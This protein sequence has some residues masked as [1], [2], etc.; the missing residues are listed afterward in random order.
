MN[1]LF[2]FVLILFF[3][4][5][6]VSLVTTQCAVKEVI[7]GTSKLKSGWAAVDE[8][9]SLSLALWSIKVFVAWDDP[10]LIDYCVG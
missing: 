4:I 1:L 3:S 7:M 8:L 9:D 10:L 6:L 2:F 5:Y